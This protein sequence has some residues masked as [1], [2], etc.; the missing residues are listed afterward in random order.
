MI[1]H[2]DF[3]YFFSR[4]QVLLKIT[5]VELL[6]GMVYQDIRTEFMDSH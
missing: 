4:S 2:F 6:G 1:K 3:Y 5:A